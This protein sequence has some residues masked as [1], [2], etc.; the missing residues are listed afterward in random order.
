MS[1]GPLSFAEI[2]EETGIK[3][4]T[5]RQTVNRKKNGMFTVI[6]GSNGLQKVALLETRRAS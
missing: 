3:E 5:I 1:S 4:G 2:A 6:E